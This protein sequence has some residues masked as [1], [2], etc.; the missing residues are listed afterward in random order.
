MKF[1]LFLIVSMCV[2]GLGFFVGCMDVPPTG[3]LNDYCGVQ[4]PDPG[5]IDGSNTPVL[6]NPIVLRASQPFTPPKA[7]YAFQSAS[8]FYNDTYNHLHFYF[9]VEK[10]NNGNLNASLICMSGSGQKPGMKTFNSIPVP[11]V[12]DVLY[13]GKNLEVRKH[14][15]TFRFGQPTDMSKPYLRQPITVDP[16]GPSSYA[17]GSTF[18]VFAGYTGIQQ[19]FNKIANSSGYL[20]WIN[21]NRPA[22]G[23]G[24]TG[25]GLNVK[26]LIYLNPVTP[27]QRAAIDHLPPP[28]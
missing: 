5:M 8:V 27:Q 24:S 4:H 3:Q 15:L 25:D 21:G 2:S 7:D 17:I 1:R 11:F 10:D 13:D 6:P 14:E 26:E 19:T 18:D 22:L 16:T 9:N 23:Q 12:S 20:L 28:K